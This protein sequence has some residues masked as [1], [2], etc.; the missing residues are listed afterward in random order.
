MVCIIDDRNDVW[1]NAPNLIK[2]KPYQFFKG[3][4]DINAP[5]DKQQEN[6]DPKSENKDEGDVELGD[7]SKGEKNVSKE[8]M[9]NVEAESKAEEEIE[10]KDVQDGDRRG[11]QSDSKHD[12]ENLTENNVKEEGEWKAE[13]VSLGNDPPDCDKVTQENMKICPGAYENKLVKNDKNGESSS[14]EISKAK[15]NKEIDN[16]STCAER[17]HVDKM[18]EATFTAENSESEKPK[19]VNHTSEELPQNDEAEGTANSTISSNATRNQGTGKLQNEQQAGTRSKETS[20]E[21]I[22]NFITEDIVR[23]KDTQDT[24]IC[25]NNNGSNIKEKKSEEGKDTQEKPAEQGK[26]IVKE[27]GN[28]NFVFSTTS[29]QTHCKA[30]THSQSHNKFHV[31]LFLSFSVALFLKCMLPSSLLSQ[32][33]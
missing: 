24:G 16:S 18:E 32:P 21:S 9:K 13:D 29:A 12:I 2:V 5:S 10:G 17:S 7:T 23:E 15:E 33:L 3:V 30:Q 1:N 6:A 26:S 11:E 22:K 28:V 20:S 27:K 31:L 4:G 19:Q 14:K 25:N 8:D